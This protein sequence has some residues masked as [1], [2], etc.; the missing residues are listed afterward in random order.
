MLRRMILF[1][2]SQVTLAHAGALVLDVPGADDDCCA[3]KV[4]SLLQTVDFVEAAGA[5]LVERK[6]C[7]RVKAGLAA[8][9]EI[10]KRVLAEAGYPVAA[11][12][13]V[14]A[15]P[16]S[17][18]PRREPWDAH[19]GLD[20]AVVSRGASVALDTVRVDGRFTVVDFGA[21]WCGPCFGVADTLAGY[22]RDHAD[23][24]VRVI[25]LDAADA[26][27]SFALPAAQEHLRF[28]TALPWLVVF[29]PNGKRLY[30]GTDVAAATKA[31]DKRRKRE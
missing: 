8:D 6:A 12:T 22:L 13:P 16:A 15:C 21:P 31:I 11:V 4:A 24:A 30:E 3:Q 23:T 17:L 7:V 20:V 10:L 18:L 27:A 19:A 29:A 26:R 2:A 25:W 1:L 28:A 9:E 5:S 14:D